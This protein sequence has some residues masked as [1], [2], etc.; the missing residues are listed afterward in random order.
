MSSFAN[1][2]GGVRTEQEERNENDHYPTHPFVVYALHKHAERQSVT[3]P[4]TLW[5]P[6]AGRGWMAWEL[7]RLKYDVFASDL[8]EYNDPLVNVCP[9]IDFL[10]S[11]IPGNVPHGVVTNPPYANNLAQKFIQKGLQ[12][13]S[14]TAMLCR[15]TFAESGRRYKMFTQTPPTAQ[16][17]FS[18][19]F[20]C[21]EKRFLDEKRVLSGMVAYA[22]WV[23]DYRF[24][25][26][27]STETTWIDTKEMY[28]EWS[29]SLTIN[30]LKFITDKVND[31]W[32]DTTKQLQKVK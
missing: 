32:H 16:F 11:S 2:Y 22:W 18:G 5:E 15:L 8:H 1:I 6:A 23:W 21:D 12:H 26:S 30:Q 20:S 10:D 27:K 9:N 31:E 13:G 24:G 25:Q 4:Q 3:I 14:Y 28:R 17:I 7:N 19:R 29:E